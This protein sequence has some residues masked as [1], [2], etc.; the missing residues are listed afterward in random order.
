MKGIKNTI[1]KES[2]NK[3]TLKGFIRKGFID[4]KDINKTLLTDYT[5][6]KINESTDFNKESVLYFVRDKN[7]CFIIDS[8]NKQVFNIVDCKLSQYF[9]YFI[10]KNKDYKVV[11]L[12]NYLPDNIHARGL[13]ID[14]IASQNNFSL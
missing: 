5:K 6:N 4:Y 13:G 10:S 8:Q 7:L 3:S 12:N 2:F 11:N 9:D 14:K 1:S